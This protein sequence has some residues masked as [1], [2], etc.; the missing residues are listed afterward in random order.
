MNMRY[1]SALVLCFIAGTVG[2][3]SWTAPEIAGHASPKGQWVARVIPG[4]D[5]GGVYGYA[6]EKRGE[7]ATAIVYR[8]VSSSNYAKHKEFKL[9]NPIAPVFA[10]IADSGELITL[11]NWHNMGIGKSVVVVYSPDGGIVR[12]L[13]LMDIYSPAELEKFRLSTSSVW[14]RCELRPQLDPRANTLEVMDALG[15]SVEIS[16]KTGEVKRSPTSR[17][18]C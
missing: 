8:L 17:S 16:L 18:G 7:A 5:K 4:T 15:S 10:A 1:I 9:L 3:D 11:D 12:S 2:A 6:G 13:G 14:W